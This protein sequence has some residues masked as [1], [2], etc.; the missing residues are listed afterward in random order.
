[1]ARHWEISINAIAVVWNNAVRQSFQ[2]KLN[3][4]RAQCSPQQCISNRLGSD[5]P[6]HLHFSVCFCM[7]PDMPCLHT[8][9][10]HSSP[11][12]IQLG[13]VRHNNTKSF[14]D[15]SCTVLR[16]KQALFFSANKIN[17]Y[18]PE[19][20]ISPQC[21]QALYKSHAHFL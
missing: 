18:I 14:L 3:Q 8:A 6:C 13:Y 17:M 15:S 1:M 9:M 7:L 11:K 20:R 16:A 19:G 5:K 12:Q 10:L 4:F 21:T 2:L